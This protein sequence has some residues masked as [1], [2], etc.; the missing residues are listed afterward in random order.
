MKKIF[1]TRKVSL[2]S[3]IIVGES[4][5]MLPR[6]NF[7]FLELGNAISCLLTSCLPSCNITDYDART[8]RCLPD[9]LS[10]I[11]HRISTFNEYGFK[12]NWRRPVAPPSLA[13]PLIL[14]HILMFDD[15]K[16]SSKLCFIACIFLLRAVT[17]NGSI[18]KLL[19]INEE[20][21]RLIIP[22]SHTRPVSVINY[23]YML[24]YA[25]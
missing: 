25:V 8:Y 14:I 5:G 20:A 7:G 24:H 11:S 16:I 13:T 10:S 15:I 9:V 22:Y 12:D 18:V 1:K 3:L 21:L 19:N 6:E 2:F 17:R 4:G 23:C